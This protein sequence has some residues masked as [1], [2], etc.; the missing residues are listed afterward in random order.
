MLYLLVNPNA[1]NGQGEND[2]KEWVK[3]LKEEPIYVNVLEVKNMMEFLSS[4]NEEDEVVLTGGDGTLNHF[5][6][7]VAYCN[8]KNKIYYVKSGSG[9]DFY[10]DN[11]EYADEFGRISLN[12]FLE[13]LPIV[14]VNG[15][16]RRF[17][18]GI[19][20]GL[21]GDTCKVGE[22]LRKKTTKHINYKV[23]ALKL[24]LG[25]FKLKNATVSVDGE[26]KDYKHVWLASTMKGRY[27]GGGVKSAPDQDRFDVENRVCVI[28][29]HKKSRIGALLAFPTF[30]KGKYKGKKWAS[31]VKG[32]KVEVKFDKP[33]ALQIDGEVVY[34]VTSYTVETN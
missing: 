30:S 6:N 31:V 25:K 3:C 7:D 13:N 15:I 14:T 34:D 24:L 18:N 10:R 23:I 21:D 4:L 11:K 2:A 1:N 19:G 22:E 16:R 17:L 27:Y 32:K 20:Y 5:A 29:M 26:T 9:N 33:C 8:L 12:R 28:C